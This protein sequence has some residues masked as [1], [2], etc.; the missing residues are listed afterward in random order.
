MITTAHRPFDDRIFH[1]EGQTLARGGYEVVII[2]PHDRDEIAGGIRI[3]PLPLRKKNGSLAAAIRAYRM[4]LKT[5]ADVYHIHDP[6]LLAAGVL[7][8]ILNGKKVIY[9]VH[10][11]YGRKILSKE[12]IRKELRPPLSRIFTVLE[13]TAAGMLYY[14]LA[15]DS[16]IR[17]KFGANTEVIGNYPPIDFM[18]MR[19]PARSGRTMKM[20][21]IGGIDRDRGSRIMP[22]I[23]KHLEGY[24][25][26]L[27]MAGPIADKDD[28]LA[29]TSAGKIAYHG[30]LPWR[31]VS[32]CLADADIGLLLL[33][34][35]PSYI[36]C[37]GEGIIKLFEYMMMKLPI[38][39]SDFP[40][41]RQLITATGSGICVDPTNP[42]KIAEAVKFLTGNPEVRRKMGENGRMAVIREYNWEKEG[43]KLIA[44]YQKAFGQTQQQ[45]SAVIS[46]DQ[47]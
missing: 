34:P 18:V 12:T 23:M 46:H 31:E 13:R 37:T 8:K 41:L 26:E 39:V 1:K 6:E 7:L 32:K 30:F 44:V 38:I 3:I 28:I 5:D 40:Y 22:E 2:A 14:V 16:N 35:T 36:N 20:V 45:G 4:A 9:D 17:K 43:R 21:Y 42:A 15:A 33:Q 47:I 19:P 10:E 27:H 11:D 29:L 25:I 24:D